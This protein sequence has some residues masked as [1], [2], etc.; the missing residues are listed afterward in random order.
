MSLYNALFGRNLFTPVLLKIIK[1]DLDQIPRFRDACVSE[2]MEHIVILTR[3][4]GG[5]RE[6]YQ[7]QNE[8]LAANPL[9]VSDRDDDFDSTYAKFKFRVP[10]ECL[11]IINA[12]CEKVPANE[13]PIG[14]FQTLVEKLQ[15]GDQSDPEVKRAL[16]IG[17]EIF[18]KIQEA[19]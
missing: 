9:F 15:T 8:A 16:E 10:T 7:D 6:E 11:P 4:G 1:V 17:K 14:K 3:T 2:D 12:T 5:N 18:A 19:N 13:N